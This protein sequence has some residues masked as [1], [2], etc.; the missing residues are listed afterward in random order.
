M[1]DSFSQADLEDSFADAAQLSAEGDCNHHWEPNHGAYGCF[2]VLCGIDMY[3]M[4][5]TETKYDETG[6]PVI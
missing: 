1:S 3:T 6:M 5:H 4:K 2:C